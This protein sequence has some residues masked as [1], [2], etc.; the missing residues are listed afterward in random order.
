[1][2]RR[3]FLRS[4]AAAVSAAGLLASCGADNKSSGSLV[5]V[6]TPDN[7]S[8]LQISDDNSPIDSNM[9][10]EAGPLKIFNWNDYLWPK[11]AKDFG[12]EYGVD[13]EI[14]T[15]YNMSEAVAKMRTGQVD[16]DL[17]FPTPDVLPKLVAGSLLQPL[18]HDYIPN[19]EANVWPELADPFYD[20]NAHYTVPYMVYST[21]IAWRKD[22]VD[23]DIG[24][25]S[26][27][28]DVFWDSRYSGRIGIYDDYREAIGMVL[29]RNGIS[30]VNTGSSKALALV[31]EQLKEMA[32][33]VK[34][35]TTIDG[36]YAKLP[37]GQFA[38]HQSWSGDI[39]AA[40]YYMPGD[41]YGDPDGVLQFWWPEGKGIVGNDTVAIPKGAKNPVLAHHFLNFLLANKNALKNFSWVGYQ[42][43]VNAMNPA[44]LVK[45][46]Y[47]VPNLEPAIL[48]R[49]ALDSDK[50]LL[51]LPANIDQKWQNVWSN[52]KSGV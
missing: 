39:I 43:P 7:P 32:D 49:K 50:Q 18:N 1:M 10:P 11:V 26:N 36:A 51:A 31:E 29:T 6:A 38:V 8:T 19:L 35:R 5:K 25:R 13:F 47:V 21:G 16:Y 46:G 14:S 17:F 40:P 22:M 48:G 15:F 27:P 41:D 45:N 4:S 12:K 9:D 52:F 30:D 2:K 20:Q 42:P 34:I 24:A 37:E 3:D 28:Y 23:E 33:K 44:T